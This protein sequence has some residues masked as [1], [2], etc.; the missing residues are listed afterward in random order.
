MERPAAH[1]SLNTL[2]YFNLLLPVDDVSLAREVL[3]VAISLVGDSDRSHVNL[4][5]TTQVPPDIPLRRRCLRSDC[6]ANLMRWP[7]RIPGLKE[8]REASCRTS[9]GKTLTR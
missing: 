4:M 6:G 5:G 1:E 7:V 2:R 9:P 8:W 3:P